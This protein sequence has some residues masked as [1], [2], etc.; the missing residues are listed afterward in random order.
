[1]FRLLTNKR[2]NEWYK[3]IEQILNV[4]LKYKWKKNAHTTNHGLFDYKTK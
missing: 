2:Y 1:M 3:S 4:L